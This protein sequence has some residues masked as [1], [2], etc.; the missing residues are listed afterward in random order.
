MSGLNIWH[1][2]CIQMIAFLKLYRYYRKLRELTL[3]FVILALHYIYI[4]TLQVV[5]IHTSNDMDSFKPVF[6]IHRESHVPDL[7]EICGQLPKL[8]NH[9]LAYVL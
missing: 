4:H 9:R 3:V 8:K 7:M 6:S 5:C 2:L 1:A